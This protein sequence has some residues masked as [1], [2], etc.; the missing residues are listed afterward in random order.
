M[1]FR[2]HRGGLD[3]SMKTVVT[4][5]TS[6]RAL[7]E[8]CNKLLRPFARDS[9]STTTETALEIVLYFDKPDER[10]GWDSTYLVKIRGYGVIGYIDSP[11]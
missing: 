2:E 1:R 8:H 5:E 3:A 6:R 9:N 10:I 11:C 4:L 7:A